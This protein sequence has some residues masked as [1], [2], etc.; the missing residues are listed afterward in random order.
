MKKK[1]CLVVTSLFTSLFCISATA[2]SLDWTP[3]LAS[4]EKGCKQ[5]DEW[6]AFR[7]NIASYDNADLLPEVGSIVL[8]EEYKAALGEIAL[9]ERED[10]YSRFEV[11][12]KYG[13]YYNIPLK[14]VGF[15]IGHSNG[16]MSSYVQLD[17]SY[18]TAVGQLSNVEY[19][20]ASHDSGDYQAKL[21]ENSVSENAVLVCDNSV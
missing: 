18:D 15:M 16:I 8:P 2:Q 20:I 7:K 6:A 1:K 4:W 21:N 12:V 9:V 19:E 14:S 10:V 11:D 5:S 3:L 13:D 17:A